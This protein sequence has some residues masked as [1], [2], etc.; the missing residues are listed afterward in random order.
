ML[1]SALWVTSDIQHQ[2]ILLAE[3]GIDDGITIAGRAEKL[4]TRALRE[5]EA[6]AVSARFAVETNEILGTALQELLKHDPEMTAELQRLRQE[7]IS[8]LNEH[9]PEPIG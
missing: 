7:R 9:Y 4:A 1:A 2:T 5:Q 6:H 3:E 8:V